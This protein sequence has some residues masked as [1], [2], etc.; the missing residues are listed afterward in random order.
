M[1]PVLLLGAGALGL[2]LLAGGRRPAPA[3]PGSV[4][5]QEGTA[6]NVPP[7]AKGGIFLKAPPKRQAGSVLV[8]VLRLTNDVRKRGEC[9][10]PP[11]PALVWSDTLA[12]SA[13]V[14]A[15]DMLAQDYFNHYSQDGRSPTDRI[16]A[17]G[18]A[19]GVPTGENIAKGQQ[20]AV[21]VV[22]AWVDS[23]GHC[24]N[25]MGVQYKY[26]GVGYAGGVWVQNF[27]G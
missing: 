12:R 4:T 8:E 16:L 1:I 9:G 13:Q 14:H 6:P 18:Y 17:A 20:T 19:H 5:T 10:Y 23:P 26:L 11:A 22:Q 15:E 21:E 2:L 25:L 24:K 27:G 3:G 7:I